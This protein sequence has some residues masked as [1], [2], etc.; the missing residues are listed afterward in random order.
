LA[1]SFDYNA[2]K[3]MAIKDWDCYGEIEFFA[4]CKKTSELTEFEHYNIVGGLSGGDSQT[5][6]Y[7]MLLKPIIEYFP[8]IDF[9]CVARRWRNFGYGYTFSYYIFDEGRYYDS[10]D[11]EYFDGDNGAF[12]DVASEDFDAE[13]HGKYTFNSETE[14][15]C[16]DGIVD[17]E[18]DACDRNLALCDYYRDTVVNPML[19]AW[20][21]NWGYSLTERDENDD[22]VKDMKQDEKICIEALSLSKDAEQYIN[23]EKTPAIKKAIEDAILYQNYSYHFGSF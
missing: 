11:D 10:P 20:I 21:L 13:K 8:K 19:A 9:F 12:W 14:T 15:L 2:P 16:L 5:V 3:D 1:E 6:I 7:K 18:S 23:R 17:L 22:P 4:T